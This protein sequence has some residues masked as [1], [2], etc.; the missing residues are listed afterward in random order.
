MF[1]SIKYT[2]YS[3]QKKKCIHIYIKKKTLQTSLVEGGDIHREYIECIGKSFVCIVRGLIWVLIGEAF[4]VLGLRFMRQGR[5]DGHETFP[6]MSDLQE[7]KVSHISPSKFYMNIISYP[8]T[9]CVRDFDCA[10]LK[11]IFSCLRESIPPF[12]G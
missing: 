3:W 7:N 11:V 10:E 12:S 1:S 6:C 2:R 9:S 4:D 5:W 8:F